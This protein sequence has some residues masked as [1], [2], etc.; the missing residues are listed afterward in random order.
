MRSFYLPLQNVFCFQYKRKV[1]VAVNILNLTGTEGSFFT[2]T[3]VKQF[4]YELL[5]SSRNVI[6]RA[7]YHSEGGIELVP[8]FQITATA[9]NVFEAKIEGCVNE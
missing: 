9:Q 1:E 7:T 6:D 4:A 5:Q 8:G 2:D 3:P